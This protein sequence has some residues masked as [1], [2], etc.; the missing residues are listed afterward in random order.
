[1]SLNQDDDESV[2]QSDDVGSEDGKPQAEGP[3]IQDELSTE[4]QEVINDPLEDADVIPQLQEDDADDADQR[5]A[6][7]N[8]VDAVDDDELEKPAQ[9]ER[10]ESSLDDTASIP[11]DTP[12]IQ[13]S[14][15]SSPR[16]RTP[17]LISA[18]SPLRNQSPSS[19]HRPF[20]RR[21]QS[22]IS[23]SPAL[24][25]RAR[26][27]NF[28]ASHSRQSSLGSIVFPTVSEPD[29][30]AAPW[31]VIRWTR[32]KKLSGQLFSEVGK[33]NFGFPT[34]LVVTDHI[35]V[36][37]SRGMVLIF[38]HQQNHKAIIGAGT[39]AVENGTVTSLAISADHTTVAAGHSTGHIFTWEISRP[40][41]PFLHILPVDNA[42]AQ[43]RKGDGH[44]IGSA[45][46]HI[47]FL[48]YRRTALVSADDKGMAFSHLATRGMGAVGR[49]VRTTRVLGRYPEVVARSAKPLKKSSVLAF[50]P[51]PLGNVEQKTDGLGLVA[52]LTP[53]LL[54]IVS[55][56]P[57]AQTQHKSA[58]PKEVAAHSAMT[59]ALAWFPGV[60]L[61]GEASETSKAKLAYAW[62][63]ILS[64]LEIHEVAPETEDET[65]KPPELQFLTR[66]RYKSEEAIV[67]VQWLSK[68]VLAALTITQQLLIIEDATMTV[69]DSFDL[70][71][72][73]VY[74]TDLY[75]QQLQAVIESHDEEDTSMHGVVADAFHMS[76]RAYKGRLFLLGF[77]DL[78][79]G[80]LTNWADRLLALMNIGDFIAAIRL[81][82]R[83]YSGHGEKLT[84]GLPED[85]DART[86]MVGEKLFDMMSASLRYAFGK[87][88]QA[89]AEIIE[90]DQ[91]M[92][93]AEACM[94]ACLVTDAQDFLFDEV[95]TWYDEHEQGALFVDVL[96]PYVL[97]SRV[98]TIPPPAVKVLIDHFATTHTPA[99]LEE[100]ICLLDTTTMDID[101]VTNLCMKYNLFDAY[102][103]VWNRALNDFI[104]PL[105]QLLQLADESQKINGHIKP[106]FDRLDNAQKIFPYLSLI[107]TSRTY[108]TSVPM[109]DDVADLAK[110]Q[111]YDFLFS[112]IPSKPQPGT[113]QRRRSMSG[114]MPYA[115]LR[116]ILTFD[117]PSFIS[118][119]NEAF[120]D[121]FLN[122][123]DDDAPNGTAAHSVTLQR[124]SYNR[125][126]IVRIMLEVMTA[127]FDPQD[128]I[129]LDMFIARNLPK[130]PQYMLLSGTTMNEIFVRL[131]HYPEITMRDDAQLSVEYLLS[132]YQPSN[133]QSLIPLLHG[134]QFYR[135][136][137]GVYR[138]ERQ[139]AEVI[140]MY[141][142]DPED[143]ELVF[144]AL[145]EFLGPGSDM[146]VQQR[147]NVLALMQKHAEDLTQ[148]DITKTSTT[149]DDVAPALHSHFLDALQDDSFRQ[150]EYLHPLFEMEQTTKK[151]RRRE[152][153]LLELY[154]RLMCEFNPDDVSDFVETIKEGDLRLSE[155]LPA[156]EKTGVIDAA[157]ILEARSGQV[158][159]SMK[160]LTKHLATLQEALRGLLGH[161]QEAENSSMDHAVD[162]LLTSIEKYTKVGIWLCQGQS[163]MS[164]RPKAASK[165]RRSSSI[166]QPLSLEE[167]LWLELIDSVVSIARDIPQQPVSQ[168]KSSTVEGGGALTT[169]RQI[170]QQVFTALLAATSVPQEPTTGASDFVFLRILR[171]FLTNA[172]K[173]SPSLSELR[174]VLSSIFSAYAHEESLL[175]LSNAMLDKDVFVHLDHVK[176]LRLRGWRPKGQVCEVCR[177]KLWGPGVGERIWEAWEQ[178]EEARKE[179]RRLKGQIDAAEEDTRGKGKA[180]ALPTAEELASSRGGSS[181]DL[182]PIVVFSCRHMYHQKCLSHRQSNEEDQGGVA[183]L[184]ANVQL[185]CPACIAET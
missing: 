82:T 33:R 31:E 114:T 32:L 102:I 180:A 91:L 30:T 99:K 67:A 100:I 156:M 66:N 166:S 115:N 94:T 178:K 141:F 174:N 92:E 113:K 153:S 15:L 9:A 120:E 129:Y 17:S 47:G 6:I 151:Q 69:N 24:T 75:S 131:C 62:S 164:Q 85:A 147:E 12:S 101:Q 140:S 13:G 68:S 53:Y 55:T 40:G 118:S 71:Q 63:N 143:Q 111:I 90:K 175:S 95:F 148:I 23:S 105:E 135:I 59:A 106:D 16:S 121:S 5:E 154:V 159:E 163:K 171:S 128:T 57:V 177:K 36:G 76:F 126:F 93:L 88:Q 170:I 77:N 98:S 35:V 49:T 134:A 2:P 45:V 54:V 152:G 184:Q 84:I 29:E 149:V 80:A 137:K 127:G 73:N 132:K 160:R 136:L 145:H 43:A 44:I 144:D 65:E 96:E 22:R 86:S 173:V 158:R 182:G 89:G 72:K 64:I 18:S 28:L 150:F 52:M 124:T 50:S 37:T 167:T 181:T 119:L 3:E 142:A 34:C 70:L 172:A 161:E 26:S 104:T 48:G 165:G 138:Q 130:Y 110:S 87:N 108:P 60:K 179:R 97:D 21:F 185:A 109:E 41:R 122:S 133:L 42:K 78:W 39:K 79:W 103:Y 107:L 8:A 46:V 20:D 123:S 176:Q 19:P 1:M 61:K 7:P 27:P 81:A 116:R 11:D 183:A 4:L 51:L 38:D 74:H 146:P 56:T 83:Y 157:V 155:V 25:P 139:Y 14:V 162:N 168:E 112:A 169:L 117:T 58:R 125:Q 10:P